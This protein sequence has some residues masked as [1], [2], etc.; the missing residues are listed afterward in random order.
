MAG[1]TT[2]ASTGADIAEEWTLNP[3]SKT[4]TLKA[5]PLTDGT[6]NA[7]GAGIAVSGSDVYVAGYVYNSKT[8]KY[9][10]EYWKNGTATALTDG[11]QTASVAGITLGVTH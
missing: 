5:T 9:V 11:T 1:S 8:G 7:F 2:S 3:N 10:A 4:A 6:Q